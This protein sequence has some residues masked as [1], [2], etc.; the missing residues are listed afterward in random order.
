[1]YHRYH[2]S[3]EHELNQRAKLTL[4][5][6]AESDEANAVGTLTEA[7]SPFSNTT[8]VLIQEHVRQARIEALR[9]GRHN[10][11]DLQRRLSTPNTRHGLSRSSRLRQDDCLHGTDSIHHTQG[12]HRLRDRN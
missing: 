11:Q 4:R 12:V 5:N 6:T 1:M 7:S 9:Q 10:P 3:V 8:S 2:K